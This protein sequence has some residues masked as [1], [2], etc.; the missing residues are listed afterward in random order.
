MDKI[1]DYG[2]ESATVGWRQYREPGA[3]TADVLLGAAAVGS[4][5]CYTA[6]AAEE[7]VHSMTR[8]KL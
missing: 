3:G 6:A 1:A 7:Y 2:G 8:L 4:V 5:W